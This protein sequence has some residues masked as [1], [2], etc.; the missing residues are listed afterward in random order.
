MSLSPKPCA[1]SEAPP[2]RLNGLDL[3][4]DLSGA[5]FV[6]ALETLIVADLH[7]EKGSAYAARGV[8]LPPYDTRATLG[9]LREVMA[10][11]RPRTL[12]SLGDSFH[13]G[14]ARE[15]LHDTDIASIRALSELCD[16]V[17]ITGNHDREPPEDLGGQV[18]GELRLGD[19]VLRHEP[20]TGLALETEISGHLHPVAAVVRRGRRVR[21]RCFAS[22][23]ARLVLPAFGAYTGGL[24]VRSESFAEVFPSGRFTVWMLGRDAV[25]ALPSRALRYSG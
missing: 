5:L 17:W 18:A 11:Y 13:D 16:M 20:S 6:P 12:V 22:D 1:S 3:V 2:I 25:Y 15:R 21:R 10:R 19:I 4:A 23:G 14:R 7:L 24:D 9:L 8:H